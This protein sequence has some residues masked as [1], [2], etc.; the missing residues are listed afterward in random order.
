MRLSAR[1]QLAG[2]VKAIEVGDLM[3]EVVIDL[4]QGQEIVAVIT[5]AAAR[6]LGLATGQPVTAV[7][8]ATEVMVAVESGESSGHQ[9]GRTCGS[10]GQAGDG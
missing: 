3:A 9:G 6:S 10:R 7:V 8:K 2:T 5:A 4:G 1:N